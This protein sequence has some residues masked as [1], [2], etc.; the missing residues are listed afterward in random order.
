VRKLTGRA[1][2]R[3]GWLGKLILQIEYEAPVIPSG[4]RQPLDGGEFECRW[5]DARVEDLA[6]FGGPL[7]IH[8]H[9]DH[10]ETR[11]AAS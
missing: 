2:Y 7:S 3:H 6:P 9:A 4:R 8:L 11:E 1:R 5:R 10:G